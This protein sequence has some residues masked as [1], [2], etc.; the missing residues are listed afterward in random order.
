MTAAWLLKRSF[1]TGQTFGR[2]FRYGFGLQTP[3]ALSKAVFLT[4]SLAGLFGAAMLSVFTV[5]FGRVTWFRW[6]RFAATQFGKCSAF[7]PYV[8]QEYVEPSGSIPRE[9]RSAGVDT[10]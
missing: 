1:R 6:V 9:R 5:P 7:S 10:R 8:Y 2:Q 3:G 4:R